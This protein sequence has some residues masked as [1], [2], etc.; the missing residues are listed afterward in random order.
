MEA[1]REGLEA[2]HAQEHGGALDTGDRVALAEERRVGHPEEP[3]GE[4]L[5]GLDGFG[6]VAEGGVGIGYEFEYPDG[7]VRECRD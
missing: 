1:E 5:I 4:G 7:D 3:A 6:E 2:V